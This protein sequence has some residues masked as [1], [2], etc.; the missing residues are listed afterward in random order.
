MPYINFCFGMN[1][2]NN[3]NCKNAS[4]EN[5]FI[6]LKSCFKYFQS[7]FFTHKK[8]KRKQLANSIETSRPGPE[9]LLRR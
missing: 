8:K 6:H 2:K 3:L 1:K 5:H 4:F 9:Q 7:Q